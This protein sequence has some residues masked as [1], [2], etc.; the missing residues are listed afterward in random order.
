MKTER[1]NEPDII[2]EKYKQILTRMRIN[3]PPEYRNDEVEDSIK[4]NVKEDVFFDFIEELPTYVN[5]VT[6]YDE[7]GNYHSQQLME[8]HLSDDFF[9][10]LGHIEYSMN[11][12]EEEIKHIPDI[13]TR[14]H[15]RDLLSAIDFQI[16]NYFAERNFY[17]ENNPKSNN[18][19]IE[20]ILEKTLEEL[21][22]SSGFLAW[23]KYKSRFLGNFQ[24][25]R[26]PV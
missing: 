21:R 10:L 9:Q 7:Y 8:L 11:C 19:D 17:R 2:F 23:K 25:S 16:E 24:L 12:Y 1:E 5:S 6:G 20:K 18:H 22:A 14:G 4:K 13:E 15:F 26:N 3:I